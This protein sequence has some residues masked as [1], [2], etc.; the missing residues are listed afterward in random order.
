MLSNESTFWRG[1]ESVKIESVKI[2]SVKIESVKSIDWL[3]ID[4]R[5]VRDI[6]LI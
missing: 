6:S 5:P 4:L 3:F 1:I 2:E